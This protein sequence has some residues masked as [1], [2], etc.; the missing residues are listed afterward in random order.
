MYLGVPGDPKYMNGS[1]ALS[2]PERPGPAT[3]NSLG[4]GFI[5][6]IIFSIRILHSKGTLKEVPQVSWHK[7]KGYGGK[8]VLASLHSKDR[9]RSCRLLRWGSFLN[10][11]GYF[12]QDCWVKAAWRVALSLYRGT[13]LMVQNAPCSPCIHR[14]GQPMHFIG[15]TA[16]ALTTMGKALGWAQWAQRSLWRGLFSRRSHFE[17]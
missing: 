10:T 6:S 7:E 14:A 8:T 15:S 5:Q 2:I 9:W 3:P 1:N 12:F 17:M 4:A 11:P 13:G 16:Q